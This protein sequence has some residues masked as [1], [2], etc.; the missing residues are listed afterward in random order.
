MFD[1]ETPAIYRDKMKE[2]KRA[3]PGFMPYFVPA[4]SGLYFAYIFQSIVSS[5][6]AVGDKVITT[7][8]DNDDALRFE[9]HRD[10]KTLGRRCGR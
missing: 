3:L 6:V 2:Y 10:G 8:L 5:K 4:K 9:L 7:Y 1:S